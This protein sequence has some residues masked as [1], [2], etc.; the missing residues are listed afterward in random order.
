M[1]ARTVIWAFCFCTVLIWSMCRT[2][3]S[4]CPVARAA[5][6]PAVVVVTNCTSLAS[7]P[8][9]L[10]MIRLITS[11][12]PPASWTPIFL[13]LRSA[14]VLIP[15]P[16]ANDTST[17]GAY[18]YTILTSAPFAI[19]SSTG[20]LDVPARSIAPDAD[21]RNDPTPPSNRISSTV[22]FSSLK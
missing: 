11:A 3:V 13:P 15:G 9:F 12:K 14:I 1:F 21:A 22:R 20:S 6:R 7:I 10:R 2:A 17:F 4:V 16:T 19:A 18:E 8:A 5:T